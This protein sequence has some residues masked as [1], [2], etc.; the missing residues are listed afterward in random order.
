MALGGVLQLQDMR[1]VYQN[2][3]S[4]SVLCFQP[5]SKALFLAVDRPIGA[6]AGKGSELF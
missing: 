5:L 6:H 3:I 2:C 4:A 1:N